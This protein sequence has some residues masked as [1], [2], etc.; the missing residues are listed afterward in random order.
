[1]QTPPVDGRLASALGRLRLVG[2]IFLWAEFSEAW[3]YES[4]PG[5][6]AAR[7]LHPGAERILVFHVVASGRCWVAAT[8]GEQLWAREGDVIVIPYGTQHR[9]GGIE[10]GRCVSIGELLA[11]PPWSTLPRITHG[12]GGAQTSILCGYLHSDDRLFDP[13]VNVFPEVFV[14]HPPTGAAANW[15]RTSIEYAMTQT[16][17][18]SPTDGRVSTRIPEFLLIEVLRLYLASAPGADHDW[19]AALHD[20]VLG[21]AMAAMHRRPEHKWTVAELAAQASVSRTALDERFH[22]V[23]RRPPIRY[24]NEWRM[25]I[26][27]DLLATTDLTVAAVARRVGY[28]AEEAFSRAFKRHLGQSPRGWRALGGQVRPRV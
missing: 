16:D 18:A 22:T 6:T 9:V 15:V 25:Y 24:L 20:P 11:P 7:V 4:L 26:A 17:Y 1:M 8:G 14:V 27:Q 10:D 21:P 19:L 5:G 13:E 3:A 28:D 12:G 2:A 23:L